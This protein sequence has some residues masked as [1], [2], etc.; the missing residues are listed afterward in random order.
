MDAQTVA[1]V[2]GALGAGGILL[3]LT[4]RGLD[5]WHN[6]GAKRRDEVDRAWRR[7]DR[8]ATRRRRIEEYASQLRRV[9]HGAPCVDASEIPPWPT[10]T[11]TDTKENR[12]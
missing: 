2:L 9:L 11:D 4:K 7:V 1:L 10:Y 6:R 5:A 3:E 12:S 8:E